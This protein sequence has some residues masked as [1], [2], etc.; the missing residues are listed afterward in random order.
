MTA[1]TTVSPTGTSY[2]DQLLSGAKWQ[3]G[4]LT[5]AFPAS[6]SALGYA[7]DDSASFGA[8]TSSE[9]TA[10]KAIMSR[11][12]AVAGVTF[13]EVSDPAAADI[14]VY[15]YRSAGPA[16]GVVQP[17]NGT[18][19]GGDI[20]LND[21]IVAGDL[22]Q[23]GAFSYFWALRA[24]GE[25]LG[26]KSPSASAGAFPTSNDVYISDSVM[27]EFAYA[28]HGTSQIA[29]GAY[30]SSPM[31]NDVA[32]IQALYGAN[33]N[34]LTANVG[35]TTY[36]FDPTAVVIFQ[37][38]YDGGGTDTF[39][40]S[41][42][43][44]NLSVDLRAGG[45]TDLGGQYAQLDTGDATK[46]PPG[47]IATPLSGGVTLIENAYGGSGNDTLI[48]NSA[49]NLLRG[50]GGDDVLKPG[51][52]NDTLTGG[53]GA[54]TFDFSDGATGGKRITDFGAG[55]VI[56]LRD[57]VNGGV[58]VE[59]GFNGLTAGQVG[60]GWNGVSNVLYVG[61]DATPGADLTIE[62]ANAI[63]LGQLAVS[64]QTIRYQVDTTAPQVTSVSTPYP[65]TY[66]PGETLDF[67]VSFDE[68][69]IVTGTPKLSVAIGSMVRQLD[70]VSGSRSNALVFRYTIQ[71]GDSANGV[72]VGM[73]WE[74]NATL[75]DAAGN[76]ANLTLNYVGSGGNVIVD[77]VAPVVGSVSVPT[78][79]TYKAGDALTF[80][81][82]FDEAVTVTGAPQLALTVG[83]TARQADYVSGSGTSALVF[84]YT[85]QSGETDADGITV[86]SLNLNSGTLKDGA[87]N[88]AA[89]TL[90]S[91]GA[92]SSVLVDGVS[93]YNNTV[94]VPDTGYYR[95][96][97]TLTFSLVFSERVVVTGTPQLGLTVGSTT[98]QADYVG[99]SGSDTLTFRY[100][101]QAGDHAPSGI[102]VNG[103]TLNGGTLTDQ[104]GNAAS[105]TANGA[106]SARVDMA[107][108]VVT[109]VSVPAAGAYKAGDALTFTVAL[110]EAVTVTGTPQ[111]ALTVGSTVRQADYVSGS[112]GSTLVFRYTV[113]S[114]D[115]DADGIAVGA[116]GLNGGTL[117]DQAGNAANLTLN[118]VGATAS[119]LV[120]TAGP[121]VSSASGPSAATYKVGDALNFTVNFSE[122][123]TVTGAPKLALTLDAGGTVDATYVSGSGTSALVFR[124]T[125]QPGNADTDGVTLGSSIV[126][127]GG[128]LKDA[129]GNDAALTGVSVPGLANV[130][131]DSV[132]PSAQSI[133]RVGAAV[134]KA[135]S[136]SFTVTFGEAVTGVD[137]SDF[138]VTATGT[139]AGTITGVSGSGAT[140]TVTLGSVT[141]DGTLRLDLKSSGTGVADAAGNPIASGFAAGQSV[142]IDN[143]APAAPTIAVVAGDDTISAGEV[144][145]LTLGGAIEA[146]ATVA[147]TIG[148][149]AK[150]ATVSGTT[151]TY[152]VTQADIDALGAG[153]KT[154]SVTAAD[155]LGNVSTAGARTVTIAA[156]ALTPE[157]EPTPAPTLADLTARPASAFVALALGGLTITPGSS[158]TA[159]ATI[160]LP[161]GSTAP[162]TAAQ[163][164]ASID[165]ALAAFKAGQITQAVFE[166]RLTLAVA[167]TTG[168]AHDAYKFFTGVTPSRAGMTWL[169]DS[170]DNPNDLTDGYYARFTVENRY[171]NFAVN[172]GKVGEGR[173]SF[174]TKYGGLTFA[175]AVAKAYGEIIGASE[176]QGAGV[177][178]AAALR[179]I[180]SQEAYFR[181]LGG[182]DLGA[183]AAMAGY[184]LSVGTSFHVGKYYGALEDYVVGAITAGASASAAAP[185]WDLT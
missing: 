33:S 172:L 170:A 43:S 16:A 5:F 44:T 144:S 29:A 117:K 2:I 82:N 120:D 9:Q 51:A 24:V 147:L 162:S 112:G 171:I 86:G 139:A 87:G 134:S 78:S 142:T 67:T 61:L 157:P 36:T 90:N 107:P 114:G 175:D 55:D 98:R 1:T 38:R 173:A 130:K 40:F 146:G 152:A 65:K 181:A 104:A 129:S 132:A 116:L 184:V 137:A 154:I 101:I 57:V 166:Q 176:A 163:V 27:S 73:L 118:G 100:T 168:V 17:P 21:A 25:A 143:T 119:V 75:K 85:I 140:Y 13:T 148:G 126:L 72:T 71:S 70:Y 76:A 159:S 96:G 62:F 34:A 69:V 63:G 52:G 127:N 136:Q 123:I 4:N 45:W 12:A 41:S 131:V 153:A 174:E 155:A 105:L 60:F 56:K 84:R 26:L 97:E 79:A 99:G 160:T 109:S 66:K 113:Q 50:N 8:L 53:A 77:G 149:V 39:N 124:Y 81:V 6:E 10:F 121:T 54:D 80:T 133:D 22:G 161:D 164:Q 125:V 49:D 115:A 106:S 89:L 182:D 32:A 145:G 150:T 122:A 68:A 37:T 7:L 83:S 74:D 35:D 19:Q 183:K 178:V 156:G 59:S 91:I 64:G 169:I 3:S 141:G 47:N 18:A 11:W 48:G 30:P 31:L 180:Q 179:Y 158:K 28:G 177:D 185:A 95:S 15:R 94:V 42:Y 14:A 138:I 20:Q 167:P 46:K 93:P 92:T 103:L 102:D 151:W 108:P 128:T 88:N 111:L 58:I 110:D 165:A 135:T 23:P